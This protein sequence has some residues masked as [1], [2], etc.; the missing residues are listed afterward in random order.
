MDITNDDD[1]LAPD[2]G[3]PAG[4]PRSSIETGNEK[5]PAQEPE[6]KASPSPERNVG[7]ADEKGG[8]NAKEAEKLLDSKTE[9]K[10]EKKMPSTGTTKPKQ[11]SATSSKKY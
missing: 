11:T 6:K 4:K 10:T 9:P 5:S 8:V 1:A 7:V 2:R 3:S